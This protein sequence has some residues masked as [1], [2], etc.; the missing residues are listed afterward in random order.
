MEQ[1]LLLKILIAFVIFIFAGFILYSILLQ[2]KNKKKQFFNREFDYFK[3]NTNNIVPLSYID[4]PLYYINMDKSEYRRAHLE[5][6]ISQYRIN[7]ALRI[8][9]VDGSK[10]T[11][12]YNGTF[13]NNGMTYNYSI[14]Y[15]G[16]KLKKSEIGCLLSHLIALKTIYE[17][18]D[19]LSLVVE[20]DI[21]FVLSKVWGKPLSKIIKDF[22]NDPKTRDF[23]IIKL[24]NSLCNANEFED[25][26]L[27]EEKSEKRCFSTAAMVYTYPAIA[28][29]IER[30]YDANTNT[31]IIDDATATDKWIFDNTNKVYN[32]NPSLLMPFDD[33]SDSNISYDDSWQLNNANIPIINI[34]NKYINKHRQTDEILL[35]RL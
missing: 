20:D 9:G 30:V 12:F 29:I 3:D 11:D 1:Y 14:T 5:N 19:E 33:T 26:S 7:N 22:Q 35:L 34:Y 28:N 17:R 25:L 32:T 6:Q 21:N 18:G 31:F 10:L 16:K 27:D 23:G 13:T 15:R 4:I 24:T 2:Y 8:E